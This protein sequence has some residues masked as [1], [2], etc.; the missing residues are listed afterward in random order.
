MNNR[1]I[2][3]I[4]IMIPVPKSG[5]N[6]IRPNINRTILR[7]GRT[8]VF[9]S[10][11]LLFVKYLDVKIIIPSLANSLGW[12]PKEPIPNQLLEPFLIVPIPGIRTSIKRI[13]Y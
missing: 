2:I 11:S 4:T 7:I 1:T 13:N 10:L 9:I 12:I 8:D 3:V 5:C 6:I